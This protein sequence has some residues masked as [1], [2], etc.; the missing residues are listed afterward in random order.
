MS[1]IC[2]V[3]PVYKIF[4]KLTVDEKI[5]WRQYLNILSNYH[6]SIICSV[7]LDISTYVEDL[8]TS[9]VS[10]RILIFPAKYFVDI[11]GYNKLMLSKAFYK[12]FK[13]Y[14]YILLYQLDAFIFR[15]E[16]DYWTSLN[17]SYIGAPWFED[18]HPETNE[19]KLW[20]VGNGGFTLRKVSDFLKVLNTSA[21][22]DSWQLILKIYTT[23][24]RKFFVKNIHKLFKRLLLGNNTFW[25]FNDY[26]IHRIYHQEDY[27]WGVFCSEK[28]DWFKVPTPE[29][30][31]GFSFEVMPRKMYELNDSKL[32][33]GCH[34]WEKYDVRFWKPFIE[35]YGYEVV[36]KNKHARN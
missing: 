32:P 18:Y 22:I 9:N 24:G 29:L 26:H 33:M 17:Y 4:Q 3:I 1:K 21:L 16:L 19:P 2:I 7:K 20:K 31:L 23:P 13:S 35:Q 30:A 34:A 25:L 5:S 14:S 12:P 36:I 11:D 15:D 8:I 28:F 27:F 10:Y 6:V